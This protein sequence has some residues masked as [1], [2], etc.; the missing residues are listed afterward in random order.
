M[1]VTGFDKFDKAVNQ[2]NIWI[3]E[4]GEE[5]QRSDRHKAYAALKAALHVLRD[6]LP[7]KEAADLGAQLPMLIRGVYYEGWSPSKAP[8]KL[9]KREQFLQAVR[10]QLTRHDDIDPAAAVTA[11]FAILIRHV[12]E[13]ELADVTTNLTQDVRSLL[14]VKAKES[15]WTAARQ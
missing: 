6:C 5:L 10:E 8:A 9:R 1:T 12:S 15:G 11:T 2:A 7:V 13:G 14:Y 4:V 3:K